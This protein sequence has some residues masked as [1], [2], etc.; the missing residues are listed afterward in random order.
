MKP[1]VLKPR[2]RSFEIECGAQFCYGFDTVAARVFQVCEFG[3]KRLV[4]R[5]NPSSPGS[6]L[7]K[8]GSCLPD[9]RVGK[10]QL[11]LKTFLG[12]L[13]IKILLFRAVY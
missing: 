11:L 12:V 10:L 8:R 7:E 2:A 3:F 9:T 1:R 5:E 13:I 4:R 6:I